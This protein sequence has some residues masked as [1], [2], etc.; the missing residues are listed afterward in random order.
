MSPETH[1]IPEVEIQRALLLV[2]E[3]R[4]MQGTTGRDK[5]IFLAK[6][7]SDAVM[8][9][10]PK[11]QPIATAPNLERVMVVGWNP[12]TKRVEGYWWY[13][14]DCV[15]DGKSIGKPFATHWFPIVK[16]AFPAAPKAEG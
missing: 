15:Q 8:A 14:E 9:E 1:T 12:P 7:I 2:Y 4:G 13:E 3:L 16:P 6:A 11:L 10:R 5:A